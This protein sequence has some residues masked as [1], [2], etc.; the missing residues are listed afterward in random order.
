[1]E[2]FKVEINYQ[3]IT[4]NNKRVKKEKKYNY[5]LKE[6]DYSKANE[7]YIRAYVYYTLNKAIKLKDH[8]YF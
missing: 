5:H 4:Q 3:D 2:L 1:M 6:L 8:Q 7:E